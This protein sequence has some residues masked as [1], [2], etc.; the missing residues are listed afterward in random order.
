MKPSKNI[1]VIPTNKP[2]RLHEYD[3]L[4]PMGLSKEPLQWRLGR[5]IC[6]TSDEL[7]KEGDYYLELDFNIVYKFT[8]GI[9]TDINSKKI[10]LTTDQELIKEGI[11]AIP[12]EF[13]EWFITNSSCEYVEVTSE[14]R[15]WKEINWITIYKIIIPD[16]ETKQVW[17]QIIETCG[18]KEEFMKSAG[19]LPKQET[20]EEVAERLYPYVNDDTRLLF[21]NGYKLAQER[22]YSEE[23]VLTIVKAFDKEFYQGIVERNGHTNEW[24]EQFKKK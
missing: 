10:I 16:E 8:S 20:L 18:G 15:N 22:S 11:Q 17:E 5:N 21:I 3:Y 4:S 24:F 9:F 13:L 12:D 19:L 2:S 23:E 7:I 6:I 14:R 1:H